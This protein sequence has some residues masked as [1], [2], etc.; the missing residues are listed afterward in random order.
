MIF[1]SNR[2]GCLGSVVVSIVLTVIVWSFFTCSNNDAPAPIIHG[3]KKAVEVATESARVSMPRGWAC[4]IPT[5][6]WLRRDLL[7]RVLVVS[8]DT[9]QW[10]VSTLV[11][12][13][14]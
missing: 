5:T 14:H 2:L 3:R 12:T 9:R 6:A 1:F 8:T 7:L 4:R 10:P 13:G 11:G